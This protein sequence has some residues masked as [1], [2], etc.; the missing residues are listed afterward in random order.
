[1]T[2]RRGPFRGLTLIETLIGAALL[3]LLMVVAHRLL[4]YSSHFAVQVRTT[5]EVQ[6]ASLTALGVLT[7][8]L[9][10]SSPSSVAAETNGVIFASPRGPDGQVAYD[11]ITGAMLWQRWVCYAVQDLQ[12]ES[13]LARY[14]EPIV[15]PVQTAPS[16]PPTYDVAYFVGAG[17][18]RR[19]VASPITQ[20]TVNSAGPGLYDVEVVGEKIALGQPFKITVQSTAK[21]GN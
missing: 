19:V 1:M 14:E 12:G 17:V 18:T 7:R 3:S 9:A 21:P 8:E 6:Q 16:V 2:G 5:E 15:P 4:I 10:Q 13:R 20:L 11:P